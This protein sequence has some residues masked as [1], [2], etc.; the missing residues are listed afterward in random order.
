VEDQCGSSRRA[1]D[2]GGRIPYRAGARLTTGRRV[3]A[4]RQRRL[5]SWTCARS[6]L[7]RISVVFA[8]IGLWREG[9]PAQ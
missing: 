2:T 9:M 3:T 5:T 4:G 8:D 1:R 7:L 6:L